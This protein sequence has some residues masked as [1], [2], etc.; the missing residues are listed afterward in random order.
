MT[1]QPDKLSDIM[2]EMARESPPGANGVTFLPSL[3][4][5]SSLDPS[6]N[7]RFADF[8][9]LLEIECSLI[10]VDRQKGR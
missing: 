7:V 6:Q 9:D 2:L 10:V 8:P 3:A 1:D 5:G 4:G